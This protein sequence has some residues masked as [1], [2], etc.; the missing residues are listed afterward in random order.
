MRAECSSVQIS[1]GIAEREWGSFS[2]LEKEHNEAKKLIK[3][4]KG[5]LWTERR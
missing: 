4:I 1:G 5:Q 2:L 3:G